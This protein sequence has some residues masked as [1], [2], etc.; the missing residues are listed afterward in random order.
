MLSRGGGQRHRRA[1]V[2][3]GRGTHVLRRRL[4]EPAGVGQRDGA[5]GG[6]RVVDVEVGQHRRDGRAQRLRAR[7]RSARST[8]AAIGAHSSTMPRLVLQPAAARLAATA[9]SMRAPDA[10]ARLEQRRRQ[11]PVRWR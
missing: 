2:D 1:Q 11:R 6:A 7:Q 9:A 8:A 10:R 5:V 3:A 4:A